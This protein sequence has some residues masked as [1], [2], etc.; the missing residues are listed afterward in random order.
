MLPIGFAPPIPTPLKKAAFPKATL[1]RHSALRPFF[2]TDTFTPHNS[3]STAFAIRFGLED[4]PDDPYA[5][6]PLEKLLAKTKE[7]VLGECNAGEHR[8]AV[9]KTLDQTTEME[10]YNT[11]PHVW[12]LALE[13]ALKKAIPTGYY[14][15]RNYIPCENLAAKKAL[16]ALQ[17][18]KRSPSAEN[19]WYWT[20]LYPT[21]DAIDPHKTRQSSTNAHDFFQAMAV[22]DILDK[23]QA[24]MDDT[25]EDLILTRWLWEPLGTIVYQ[26]HENEQKK[27]PDMRLTASEN[28]ESFPAAFALA[29]FFEEASLIWAKQIEA[30]HEEMA[31]ENR[32]TGYW[33]ELSQN[34]NP[35]RGLV[36]G[37]F[38]NDQRIDPE[39][40]RPRTQLRYLLRNLI[41]RFGYT[42]ELFEKVDWLQ[43]AGLY[44]G[45]QQDARYAYNSM[46]KRR[47]QS[48]D[49]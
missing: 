8:D 37:M 15:N 31:E 44:Q 14:E 38:S 1:T 28:S 9:I 45:V 6:L 33:D 7:S 47:E 30:L 4:M 32:L 10:Q 19:N 5:P 17:S 36:H 27:P 2:G 35:T 24:N 29:N 21:Y 41:T 42:D 43:K 46:K 40:G 16:S 22:R 3:V 26:Q 25:K 48:E 49:K 13:E 18:G 34:N 39:K 20:V 12:F 23:F 11:Q